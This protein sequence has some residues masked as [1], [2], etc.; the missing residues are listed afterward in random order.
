[1]NS[2]HYLKNRNISFLN[3]D[4]I[5]K[6]TSHNLFDL[7]KESRT[8]LGTISKYGGITKYALGIKTNLGRSTV[9]RRLV[10]INNDANSLLV[11][12]YIY[13]KKGSKHKSGKTTTLYFLT[14]KGLLA[15][16][17]ETRFD[18]SYL[19]KIYF[20][21]FPN[22]DLLPKFLLQLIKNHICLFFLWH[23]IHGFDLSKQENIKNYF[24]EWNNT[25]HVLSLNATESFVQHRLFD[26]YSDIKTNFFTLQM[27]VSDI[28]KS[29][30]YDISNV[31]FDHDE[32]SNF[33][34]EIPLTTYYDLV[35]F[36]P[37]YMEMFQFENLK[38]LERKSVTQ[39]YFIGPERDYYIS[40][41]NEQIKK[42]QKQLHFKKQLTLSERNLLWRN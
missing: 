2:S 27:F 33:H 28:L 8:I 38:L 4:K 3:V 5:L 29:G 39:D 24:L 13:S 30:S 22:Y 36:W 26:N 7:D 11:N 37:Y 31:I 41:C 42:F 9:R 17:S 14:L 15:S 35:K 18:E 34:I 20:N 40:K 19:Q 21:Y 1:M 25:T 12:N 23:S 6:G 32:E 16:L 10:G